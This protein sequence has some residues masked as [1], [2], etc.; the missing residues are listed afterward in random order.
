MNQTLECYLR[1]YVNYF[2]DDWVMLLPSAEY[3]CNQSVNA[4]TKRSPFSLVLTFDPSMNINLARE[5]QAGENEAARQRAKA[6]EEAAAESRALWQRAQETVTEY[7]NRKH[8]AKIYAPGDLVMLSAKNI[9]LRKASKKLA[10]QFLGPFEILKA[11]G[12][13]AYTLRLPKKYGR[14]HNTFHVSLLEAYSMREGRE[15]PE[16]IDIDG[17]QEWE[18]ERILDFKDLKSGRQFLVR[19]KGYSEAEDT[20]EPATH[21][22]NAGEKLGEFMK[23]RGL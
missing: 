5:T 12:Q 23:E 18:V 21:L 8:K 17:D 6:L 20:W 13:N 22:L 14:L 9:R 11:V 15:A 10:D 16:P 19:W 1:C 3:A 2:Q 7:Y 4:T